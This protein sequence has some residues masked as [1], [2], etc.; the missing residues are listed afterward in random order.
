MKQVSDKRES[1]LEFIDVLL[2][3]YNAL[4]TRSFSERLRDEATTLL[5]IDQAI[6]ANGNHKL[7]LLRAVV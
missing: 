2:R 1:S 3:M 5:D 4:I 7:Q 6:R